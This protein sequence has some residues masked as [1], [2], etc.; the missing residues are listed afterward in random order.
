MCR[1]DHP[2]KQGQ[3][4]IMMRLHLGAAVILSWEPDVFPSSDDS[5]NIFSGTPLRTLGLR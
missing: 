3:L 2:S 5:Y 4:P 1:K